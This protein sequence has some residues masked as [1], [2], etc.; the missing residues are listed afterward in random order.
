MAARANKKR[1]TLI[2]FGK[3]VRA[4]R[5]WRNLSQETVAHKAKVHR[6]YIGA[7]ERGEVNIS[8]LTIEKVANALDVK[9][10]DLTKF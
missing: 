7:I 8:L 3:E 2:K 4:V 5:L 9:I 10:Y 1:A 6:T